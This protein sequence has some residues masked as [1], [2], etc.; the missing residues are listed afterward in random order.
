VS[1]VKLQMSSSSAHGENKLHFNVVMMS[2]FR[3]HIF[4]IV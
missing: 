3:E 4:F 2:A 1:V